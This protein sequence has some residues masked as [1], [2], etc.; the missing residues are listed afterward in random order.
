KSAASQP[1]HQ[2]HRIARTLR[3]QPR[4]SSPF[5]PLEHTHPGSHEHTIQIWTA[6]LLIA[7]QQAPAQI[8]GYHLSSDAPHE[9]QSVTE[10]RWSLMPRSLNRTPAG[11][12][13]LPRRAS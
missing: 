2:S 10:K 6:G 3:H 5:T 4:K 9:L 7:L 8:G 11:D 1:R 13:F 12:E